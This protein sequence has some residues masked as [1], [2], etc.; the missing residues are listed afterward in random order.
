[1]AIW[2]AGLFGGDP[3]ACEKQNEAFLKNA[4]GGQPAVKLLSISRRR[5]G[6][7]AGRLEGPGRGAEKHGIK[8]E[9]H[10]TGGGHTWINWRQYLNDYLQVLFK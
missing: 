6:L 1:M 8:H 5:Q 9:L 3:A 10:I 4:D 7:R 2:S